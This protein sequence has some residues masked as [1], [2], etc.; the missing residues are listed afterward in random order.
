MR[1][2]VRTLLLVLGVIEILF[3]IAYLLRLPA[4]M[5]L[6][7]F[8]EMSAL[9]TL[10]LASFFATAAANTLWPLL[11]REDSA[12]VET[13]LVYATALTPLA[14]IGFM[15]GFVAFAVVMVLGALIGVGL[16]L[17]SR[18]I[19]FRDTRPL[20]ALVRWSFVVFLTLIVITGGMLL[21]RRPGVLPWNLTP[22][23]ST[24]FGWLFM[25]AAVFYG[26]ALLRPGWANASGHLAAFL[27]YDV[28]MLLPLLTRLPGIAPE[29]R[30]SMYIYVAS[31]LYSTGLAIYYLFI[32]KETRVIG[33]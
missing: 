17:W 3:C 1:S 32:N 31:L 5:A 7:P 6:W 21:L 25:S 29:F 16:L 12:I 15:K 24:V 4:A 33:S 13:G 27:S 28:V 8:P 22:D 11:I 14:I 20:P 2:A 10:L 19:P 30:L 18:G 26:Y 9:S 23:L